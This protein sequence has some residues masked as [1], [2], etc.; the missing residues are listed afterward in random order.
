MNVGYV[1]LL[2]DMRWGGVTPC[3]STTDECKP[4]TYERC[5]G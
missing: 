1:G 2:K 5:E 4:F 3:H